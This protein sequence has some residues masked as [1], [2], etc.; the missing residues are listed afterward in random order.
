MGIERVS[1][2]LAEDVIP[3]LTRQ[4]GKEEGKKE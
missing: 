2:G 4:T 3:E 1:H